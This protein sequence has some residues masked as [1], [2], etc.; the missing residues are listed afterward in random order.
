[1]FARRACGRCSSPAERRQRAELAA[2]VE[3]GPDREKHGVVRWR[4]IDFQLVFKERFGVDYC[5]RYIGTLLKKIGFSHISASLRRRTYNG[6]II[7]G[8]KK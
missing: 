4:R 1:M 2:I 5:E 3:A 7:G 8:F 6:W